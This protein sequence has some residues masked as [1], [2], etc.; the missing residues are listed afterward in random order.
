MRNALA[1]RTYIVYSDLLA[2]KGIYGII[3]YVVCLVS[4][5]VA[6]RTFSLINQKLS[7]LLCMITT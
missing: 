2:L 3:H 5:I 7:C 6:P 4:P 1:K